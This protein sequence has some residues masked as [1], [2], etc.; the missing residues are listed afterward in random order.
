MNAFSTFSS[1]STLK[2]EM[3]VSKNG[4]GKLEYFSCFSGTIFD[5]D[6]LF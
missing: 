2:F 5:K 1:V 3:F 4:M 6:I